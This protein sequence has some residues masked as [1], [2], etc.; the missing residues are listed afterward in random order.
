MPS[1]RVVV[2][3]C[4]TGA[5]DRVVSPRIAPEGWDF[6]CFTDGDCSVASPWQ[7]REVPREIGMMSNVK[8]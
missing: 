5:Y 8:R 4:V 6:I 1:P 7:C 2:Y 3:T